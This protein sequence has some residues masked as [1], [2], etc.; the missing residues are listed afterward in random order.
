M[1]LKHL[2]IENFREA[3]KIDLRDLTEATILVGPNGAG[4]T[5]ILDAVR[6]CLTGQCYDQAGKRIPNEDLIGPHGKAATIDLGVQVGEK[7]FSLFLTIKKN[8]TTLTAKDARAYEAFP[9]A[10]GAAKIRAALCEALNTDLARIEC[11]VNPRAYLLGPELGN[12]LAELCAG[13]VD[14]EQVRRAAG[15]HWDSISELATD[16]GIGWD[17]TGIGK[18]GDAAYKRRTEVKKRLA[19]VQQTIADRESIEQP[20]DTKGHLMDPDKLQPL[21]KLLNDLQAKR[22][23][24]IAE[25]GRIEA[26]GDPALVESRRNEISLGLLKER[27]NLAAE[28]HILNELERSAA[29]L[30][31]TA[32]LSAEAVRAVEDSWRAST[33][34]VEAAERALSAMD[35][36]SGDCPT[37][38]RPYT[39]EL[40]TAMRGPLENELLNAREALE[41]IN[42][43]G[44]RATND[45]HQAAAREAAGTVAEARERVRKAEATLCRLERDLAALPDVS[46]LKSVA[47]LDSEIAAIEARC[48]DGRAKLEVL[49]QWAQLVNARAAE[50][51]LQAELQHLEW[52]IMAFR[53]GEY[54]KSHLSDAK[55]AF[56][57]ACNE[58]LEPYGYTLGVAVDGKH[59]EV[60]L[61]KEGHRPAPLA[62]CSKAELVLAGWAVASAF[63]G[64]TPICLDDMDALYGKTK[65]ILLKS[66]SSRKANS[67]VIVAGAWTAPNVD[68]DPLRTALPQASV[69]WV[70]GG[71]AKTQGKKV[72]A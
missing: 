6:V 33:N 2:Y 40:V 72:A 9:G 16:A 26:I 19:V 49:G 14:V 64:E 71:E 60:T 43:N 58:V 1:K 13:S 63:A 48:L 12:M 55:G 68:L 20:R 29:D 36:V 54:L 10:E 50:H 11:A 65:N 69:V 44:A 24:L 32:R 34:R 42:I 38:G 7:T 51:I 52:A 41:R 27:T 17:I 28:Q 57:A 67:P 45:C 70:D 8:G 25:R 62:Q 31:Q 21:T 37:C 35:I 59:V 15:D 18:L 53:D 61:A 3:R 46:K 23:S 5:T 56:E 66:L 47:E 4:K 39:E 22:D 30:E